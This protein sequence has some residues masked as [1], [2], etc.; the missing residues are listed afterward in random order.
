MVSY[1]SNYRETVPA[2]I[3]NY[4]HGGQITFKD[5]MS[6]RVGFY[7]GSLNDGKLIKI[8]NKSHSVHSFLYVDMIK[9]NTL[10]DYIDKKDS[11][12]GYHIHDRMEWQ[13]YDL[14]PKG[15]Y[16]INIPIRQY[17]NPNEKPYCFSLIMERDKEKDDK[18]GAEHF[19]VTFLYADADATYYQL[20]VREY[21]KAPWIILRRYASR[22]LDKIILESHCYPDYLVCVRNIRPWRGYKRIET[23]YHKYGSEEFRN[24]C[25]L[26]Q[27]IAK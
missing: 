11:F 19:V 27:F 26:Y 21:S 3:D 18:W 15:Q 20:F 22:R 7:P 12:H 1:L 14:V 6:S 23:E 8:G 25:D 17:P 13:E 24:T 5:I 2:W 9:R 4:L 16:P 10:E